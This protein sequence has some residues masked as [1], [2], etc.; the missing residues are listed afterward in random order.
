V[1]DD[2]GPRYYQI[3]NKLAMIYVLCSSKNSEPGGLEIPM[4]W[5]TTA[6]VDKGPETYIKVPFPTGNA[7]RITQKLLNIDATAILT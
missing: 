1:R 2:H 6:V 7:T 5:V 4:A 3:W